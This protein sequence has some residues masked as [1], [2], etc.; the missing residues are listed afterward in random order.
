MAIKNRDDAWAEK[1]LDAVAAGKATM[2]QRGLPAI[3]ERGGGL[4]RIKKLAR[5]RG[6][7]LLLLTDDEGRE[8]VAASL[9]PFKVLC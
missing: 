3:V 2:S 4:R 6:V 8:L 7:H 1:W 5:A 9:Q